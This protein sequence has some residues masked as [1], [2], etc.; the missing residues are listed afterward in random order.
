MLPCHTIMPLI[1]LGDSDPHLRGQASIPKEIQEEQHFSLVHFQVHHEVLTFRNLMR[2]FQEGSLCHQG[3][4][5]LVFPEDLH[6][7]SL[8]W[9]QGLWY[10]QKG[11][12]GH[13][14]QFQ[15][16]LPNSHLK[17]FR[18][19]LRGSNPGGPPPNSGLLWAPNPGGPPPRTELLRGPIL[20]GPP[21]SV[22]P[23]GTFT[24]LQGSFPERFFPRPYEASQESPSMAPQ[25]AFK[26]G[27]SARSHNLMSIGVPAE[28]RAAL[29]MPPPP[30]T[31]Q[32]FLSLLR[33]K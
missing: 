25:G 31:K 13:F 7:G 6:Q 1:I 29:Y 24:N 8:P 15:L 18:T 26:G 4:C 22:R 12:L 20:S 9:T 32:F 23:Q 17:P 3:R 33:F 21:P 11:L 5:Q 30:P 19:S 16:L 2:F 10:L 14:S 28:E 27:P